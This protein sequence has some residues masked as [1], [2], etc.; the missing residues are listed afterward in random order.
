[1]ESEIKQLKNAK[2]GLCP[3]LNDYTFEQ[4]DYIKT[5]LELNNYKTNDYGLIKSQ[6]YYEDKYN[7][8][9]KL[10]KIISEKEAVLSKL[11]STYDEFLNKNCKL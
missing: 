1:M 6:K 7:T 11:K 9:N 3:V 5:M 2:E 8:Y 4:K 10:S